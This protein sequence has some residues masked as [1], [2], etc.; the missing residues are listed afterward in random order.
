MLQVA[1]ADPRASASSLRTTCEELLSANAEQAALLEALLTLASSE[2]GLDRRD[3]VKPNP[4][5]TEL[6]HAA[7]PR[8]QAL[9]VHLSADLAS[10]AAIG[11]PALVRRLI[12]N[13]LDNALQY[14]HPGGTIEI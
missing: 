14:N 13:L 2:R 11:D 9:T 12:G 7:T 3:P 4:I 10:A 5:C 6:L 1:L 8:A